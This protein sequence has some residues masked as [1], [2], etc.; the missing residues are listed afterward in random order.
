MK[1]I[2]TTFLAILF[3]FSAMAEAINLSCSDV[4][5][6]GYSFDPKGFKGW[7]EEKFNSKWLIKYDG[8]SDTALIDGNEVYAIPG[9]GTVILMDYTTNNRT[10]HSMMSYAI[11]FKTKKVTASRVGA[12]EDIM[13]SGVKSIS[14]EFNCN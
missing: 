8:K 4:R 2:I 5:A 12:Y 14:I 6:Y 10:S 7:G 3:S 11:N 9:N 1:L 13:G